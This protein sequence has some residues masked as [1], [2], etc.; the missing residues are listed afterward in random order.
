MKKI[1][2]GLLPTIIV[3]ILL[4]IL[5]GMLSPKWI[6]KSL[7]TFNSLFGGFL[8]FVVPLIIIGFVAPGIGKLGAKA[9]KLLGI[10]TLIAYISTIIAGSLAF[11]SGSSIFPLFLKT[12][13][14]AIDAK[15]PE[16][17]LVTP[18]FSLEF[19]P[20]MGVMS[21]LILAFT[22][23]LGM[24]AI[25]GSA[26]LKITEEFGE[27][28][29]KL[30]K[31]VI[32]PLLPFHILG[33]FANMTYTGEVAIILTVFAKVFVIVIILHILYLLLQYSVAGALS[34]QNPF[35]LL[36]NMLPAYFTALG[37]QSSAA[38]I[39]V[40][41]EQT[42]K[43]GVKE[44]VAHFVIPLSA[45][46]HLSGSTITIVSCSIAVMMLHD[47]SIS[48]LTFLPFILMLG[49]TMVAA[50][51]IPG[52]AI[53]AALGPLESILGFDGTLLS[54]MIALYIAQDSFG[55]ACNVTG[56]GA[57]AMIVNKI[58]GE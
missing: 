21:A 40:T 43:N 22:L 1:R 37:T 3:A 36:K 48:F 12:G 9:G 5:I 10:T 58:R 39:P 26:L 11:L 41:M 44:S 6:L 24:A 38:T 31:V 20:I 51:G 34:K 50:P 7:A 18:Y 15:N 52:G 32:I 8:Q 53:M 2:F 30:I 28:V 45:T 13:S 29:G 55:T 27:I 23:G 42:K 46:I 49:V 19:E 25:K 14:L 57:I 33:I 47:M 17:A 54:L 35:Q 4:G 56:D 16:E